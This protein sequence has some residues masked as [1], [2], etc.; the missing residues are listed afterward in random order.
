M[1]NSSDYPVLIPYAVDFSVSSVGSIIKQTKRKFV[2]RFG[3]THIPSLLQG[4]VGVECRGFELE[5]KVI[6]SCTSGHLEIFLNNEVVHS[7]SRA[8]HLKLENHLQ[9][10]FFIPEP[11]FRGGHSIKVEAFALAFGEQASEHQY[12]MFFDGQEYGDFLSICDLG[13]E[14]MLEEYAEALDR[15]KV[16][17]LLETNSQQS[18]NSSRAVRL[19]TWG[20]Q[21][22]SSNTYMEKD[23]CNTWPEMMADRAID[24]K[25]Q[26]DE[27]ILLQLHDLSSSQQAN[28]Q[29]P[30]YESVQVPL[31]SAQLPQVPV[32]EQSPT[33]IGSNKIYQYEYSQE[34]KRKSNNTNLL[35]A[36]SKFA[37]APSPPRI[38][39]INNATAFQQ[40]NNYIPSIYR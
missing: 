4:K 10:M 40:Q 39:S 36:D 3:F 22:E 35:N 13:T 18:F 20:V 7:Q 2:W 26:T 19:N 6:W 8:S 9:Y 27:A 14:K 37:T 30:T 28:P 32:L 34:N 38:V 21:A 15:I 31:V 11:I 24:E 5:L 12:S 33:F 16:S 23:R 17:D 25:R 1:K 29:T